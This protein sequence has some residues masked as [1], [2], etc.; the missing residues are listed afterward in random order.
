MSK[1][2]PAGQRSQSDTRNIYNE[3]PEV[4]K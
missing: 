1:F 3:T 4:T 2:T